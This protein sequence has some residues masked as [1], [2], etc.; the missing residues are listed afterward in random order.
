MEEE[1]CQYFIKYLTNANDQLNETTLSVF[2]YNFQTNTD[3]MYTNAKEK[4][5]MYI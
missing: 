3:I 2:V 4:T 1:K 5:F